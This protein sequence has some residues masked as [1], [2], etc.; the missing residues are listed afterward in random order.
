MIATTGRAP[1][2]TLAR[3]WTSAG[4]EVIALGH[5]GEDAADADVVLLVAPR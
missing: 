5:D 3:L 1:S 2:G 4:H